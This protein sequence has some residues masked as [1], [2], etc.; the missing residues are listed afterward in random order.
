VFPRF[1][2]GA[3]ARMQVGLLPAGAAAP[4]TV[5]G[6]ITRTA[7]LT[8]S[9]ARAGCVAATTTGRNAVLVLA[10]AA[11]PVLLTMTRPV[12]GELYSHLSGA[13]S[14]VPAIPAAVRLAGRAR[15]LIGATGV[16]ATLALPT[17]RTAICGVAAT[18]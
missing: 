5:P 13:R 18:R 3:K 15:F 12:P 14:Q 2:L 17:G 11:A 10:P 9:P 4:A 16:Q 7:E 8:L 6:V 1:L